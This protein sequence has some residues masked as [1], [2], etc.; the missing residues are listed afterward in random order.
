VPEANTVSVMS[1][2]SGFTSL[3]FEPHE[4]KTKEETTSVIINFDFI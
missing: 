2:R 4:K 1:R 3:D